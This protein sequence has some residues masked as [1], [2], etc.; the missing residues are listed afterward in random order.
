MLE[1]IREGSQGPLAIT[2]VGLIIISFAVTGVG[3]YLGSSST[4]AA[5][6]VN[7]EDITLNE[8]EAAYQN[9]RARMEAQFG[10]S[11]AAA[12]ASETYLETFRTQV[13]DQLIS[14]KLLE[15]QAT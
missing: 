5:A 7:G 13:L 2:I 15:Q 9:Q 12:F 10:E 14:D 4:P 6:T 11:V 1:K 8:V 3:S